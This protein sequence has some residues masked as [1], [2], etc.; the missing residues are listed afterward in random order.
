MTSNAVH[1][2]VRQYLDGF[3]LEPV[4]T[5]AATYKVGL[6][7]VTVLLAYKRQPHDPAV[8][9]YPKFELDQSLRNIYYSPSNYIHFDSAYVM[10][11]VDGPRGNAVHLIPVEDVAFYFLPAEA[12]RDGQ[13]STLI[14][15]RD[16]N[17][18]K[19]ERKFI[20]CQS[21]DPNTGELTIKDGQEAALAELE[22]RIE[23]HKLDKK[24]NAQGA[25][26]PQTIR[27][28]LC[29]QFPCEEA[30]SCLC[31][32]FQASFIPAKFDTHSA[33]IITICS[34][35]LHVNGSQLI[36]NPRRSAQGYQAT[37]HM[38][39]E[40]YFRIMKKANDIA[41]AW[42]NGTI[43]DQIG[44]IPLDYRSLLDEILAADLASEI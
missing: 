40:N 6:N 22:K 29:I 21:V 44:V 17:V 38:S 42:M 43:P 18:A 28:Q 1:Q 27:E 41:E 2:F 31:T 14:P 25:T 20:D 10:I 33:W 16:R 34:S 19:W 15:T 24:R 37:V 12:A 5:H 26:S 32:Y 13:I 11:L 23:S 7:T 3:G 39:S 30:T 4:D 36:G 35:C 9:S 8:E